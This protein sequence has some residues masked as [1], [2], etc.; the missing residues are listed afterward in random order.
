V[1]TL[2]YLHGFRSSSQSVKAGAL[3]TAAEALPEAYRPQL[4][5]PD[6]PHRPKLAMDPVA[7]WVV[8]HAGSGPLTFVGSSLGG[9]YA[10]YLCERFDARA[11]V[12]NPTVRPV[13]DL[14]PY[15]GT[16]TNLYT[17]EAFEVN[18]A[19]LR[20]LR[21]L[22]VPRITRPERYLL[23]VQAGDEVLDYRLA[24]SHYAGA[25]Q[26]VQGGGD[27]VFAGFTA[28]IAPILRFAGVVHPV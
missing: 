5:I 8:E 4:Y 10:T 7:A 18:Q 17:G 3:R 13:E 21:E 23:L 20:E 12:I 2:V 16:Q 22:R 9:Y 19:H 24:V 14:A 25:F 6:L 28:E 1:T 15:L 27:H 26:F 11:V